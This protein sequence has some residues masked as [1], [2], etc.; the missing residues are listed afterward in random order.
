MEKSSTT[1]LKKEP[2]FVKER[3]IVTVVLYINRWESLKDLL[4]WSCSSGE[5]TYVSLACLY[6]CF[7]LQW[8]LCFWEEYD[9]Y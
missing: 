6:G 4:T 9:Q 1:E 7:G 5:R 3:L 2:N 8:S